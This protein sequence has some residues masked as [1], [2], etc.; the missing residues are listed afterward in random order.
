[1]TLPSPLPDTHSTQDRTDTRIRVEAFSDPV[2]E[3]LGFDPRRV[4]FELCYVPIIGPS[5]AWLVRRLVA[6]LEARPE[7]YDLELGQLARDL[8][9]GDGTGRNA[10]VRHT[11]DRVAR[12]GLARWSGADTY[13]V[14]RKV[15]PLNARQLAR[16]GPLPAAAHRRITGEREQARNPLLAAALSYAARGWPVLPL[17]PLSKVPEG[18]LAPHGLNDAACDEKRIRAW[19]AASPSANVGIRTGSGVD[20]I[21]VDNEEARAALKTRC[22]EAF[23]TALWV[24]TGRGLHLYFASSGLPSRSAV[25]PGID[26]RGSGGYV[27]AP[28]SAHPNGSRYRFVDPVTNATLGKLPDRL[29]PVPQSLLALGQARPPEVPNRAPV[30][31]RNGV[32]AYARRALDDECAQVA[33]TVEGQRNDRLNRAAFAMGTLVGADALDS[34]V[35]A[36]RLL[37]AGRRAGL[38]EPEAMRTIASGLKAGMARPRQVAET[39]V[40][41]TTT[42]AGRAR[43][44]EPSRRYSEGRS[45]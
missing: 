19:W 37:E 25:L 3:E 9:L 42:P 14:R 22:P 21:D 40:Q 23:D 36:A 44:S 17:R 38:E 7:G 27:V 15:P 41:R 28:P 20:V 43:R 6:G 45:R 12:F 31:L 11:L 35:A 13:Q 29:G 16:L 10:P 2:C 30:P 33:G 4:Y 24:A 34:S 1:M 26:V 39:A 18:S 5:S 8:G 32:E